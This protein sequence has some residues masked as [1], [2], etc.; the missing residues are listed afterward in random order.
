MKRQ[1]ASQTAFV[2]YA[3]GGPAKY[4]GKAMNAAHAKLRKD[5]MLVRIRGVH[6]RSTRVHYRYI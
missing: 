1:A 2:T 3:F 4:S 5:G 6:G